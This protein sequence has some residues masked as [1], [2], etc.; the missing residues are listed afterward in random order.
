MH[1]RSA[2]SLSIKLKTKQS[3]QKN[4]RGNYYFP[5]RTATWVEETLLFFF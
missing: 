4:N 5:L 3:P 1:T 2:V